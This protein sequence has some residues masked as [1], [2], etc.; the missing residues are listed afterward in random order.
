MTPDE[1]V[2]LADSRYAEQAAAECPDARIADVYQDL[3]ARWPEIVAGCRRVAAE[4]GFIAP[5]VRG[6]P[7]GRSGC[8]VTPGPRPPAQ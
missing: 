4:A 7:G 8:F 3:P 5:A 6:R 1:V 2:V